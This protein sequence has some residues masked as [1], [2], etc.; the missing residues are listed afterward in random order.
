MAQVTVTWV[1][2]AVSKALLPDRRQP[3]RFLGFYGSTG[4]GASA[5]RG[6][7]GAG[8]S[9]RA[10]WASRVL[11][12]GVLRLRVGGRA[13]LAS[14]RTRFRELKPWAELSISVLIGVKN[15]R[16][17]PSLRNGHFEYRGFCPVEGLVSVKHLEEVVRTF[18]RTKTVF[19]WKLETIG[20]CSKM[21][22]KKIFKIKMNRCLMATKFNVPISLII[23]LRS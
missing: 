9:A 8:A 20:F 17:G 23:T 16:L 4:G 1:P 6:F 13:S 21:P 22:M 14:L 5:G 18:Q 3:W 2:S 19:V 15:N 11:Q 10:P 12:F 7:G